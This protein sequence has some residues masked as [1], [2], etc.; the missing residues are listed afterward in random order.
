MED[1][2]TQLLALGSDPGTV[3]FAVYDGHGGPRVSRYAA[4]HLHEKIL[5]HPLY[6]N[7]LPLRQYRKQCKNFS[8][9]AD[10]GCD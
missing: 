7:G 9:R 5:S 2:H 6:G 10:C 3:F 1:A 8:R 4:T